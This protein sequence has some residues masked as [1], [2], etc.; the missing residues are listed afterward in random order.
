MNLSKAVK[1]CDIERQS[2]VKENNEDEDDR[3]NEIVTLVFTVYRQF[4]FVR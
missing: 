2:C 1:K 4:Y 3:G